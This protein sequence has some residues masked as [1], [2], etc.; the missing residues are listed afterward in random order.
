MGKIWIVVAALLALPVAGMAQQ[1]EAPPARVRV[2]MV[3]EHRRAENAGLP[4]LIYF[5][6]ISQVSSEV[7][8]MVRTAEFRAGDR[9]AAGD[10]LVVLDTEFLDQD[11]ALEKQRIAQ[12]NVRIEKARKNLERYKHLL[13]SQ[14]ASEIDRDN[15]DF[16]HR[17]LIQE[18]EV[19][20]R[21]IERI[22][23]QRDRCVIRAPFDALVLGKGTEV[24]EWVSPGATLCRLGA[25]NDVFAKVPVSEG[26][27]RHARDAEFADVVI[28]AYDRRIE[29]RVV[30]LLPEADLQTRNVQVRVRLP[31]LE[32][33]DLFLAENMSATVFLPTSE[34]RDLRFFPRDALIRFQG[35]EFVYTVKD[36]K[37]VMLPVNV[38]AFAGA[39][40]GVDDDRI[41]AGMSVVVDGN[42]RLRPDQPVQIS[43]ER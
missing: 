37:A 31:G 20:R 12:L 28:D 5:D 38:V 19:I 1:G 9:V 23:L 11:M 10:V 24:G 4:G 21:R 25:A 42:Q 27:F 35:N 16:D 30:G 17:E 18:R 41:E 8:G 14:A 6:R 7:S 26:L 32:E 43:E 39:E 2:A 29:G 13:R 22:E 40:V 34:K 3:T 33:I 15:L 36:G